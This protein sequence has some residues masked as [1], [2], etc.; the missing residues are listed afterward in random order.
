MRELLLPFGVGLTP[1]L[2]DAIRNYLEL[3][4][5]WSRK[6]NLTGLSDP[7]EILQRHFGESLFAAS[8]LPGER[9]VLYD[10]G[11]GAGF[12]GLALKLVC[13]GWTVKLV[14]PNLKKAVFLSEAIR[15]L[16]FSGVEVIRLRIE[17]ISSVQFMADIVTARAVGDYKRVLEWSAGALKPG[18]KVLLWLGASQAELL[19]STSGWDWEAPIL[20]PESRERVLLAGSPCPRSRGVPRGT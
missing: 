4:L 15:A 14:E 3:L 16:N 5:R 19:T 8:L 17:Q 11:S 2:A 12:P 13:P 9:G 7:R 20:I 6:I 18:G 10:V 1:P